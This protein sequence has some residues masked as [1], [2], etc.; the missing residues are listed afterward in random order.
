MPCPLGDTLEK[1]CAYIG[2]ATPKLPD[3]LPSC[4]VCH[5]QAFGEVMQCTRHGCLVCMACAVAADAVILRQVEERVEVVRGTWV[6]STLERVRVDGPVLAG[7]TQYLKV[8]YGWEIAED[9]LEVRKVVQAH[10]WSC[11]KIV[12]ASGRAFATKGS[13][14]AGA[15]HRALAGSAPQG[16]R[17][18]S[19]LPA[20]SQILVCQP[21]AGPCVPVSSIPSLSPEPFPSQPKPFQDECSLAMRLMFQMPFQQ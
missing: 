6:Y 13:G 12:V 8:P 5:R 3:V 18:N 7:Q 15:L 2:A 21:I 19:L 9:S 10:L 1:G 20:P 4:G 11:A 17:P 14:T 16:Y